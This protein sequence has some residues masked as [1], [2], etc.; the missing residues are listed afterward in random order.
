VRYA[1]GDG[2]VAAGLRDLHARLL[3]AADHAI[4]LGAPPAW[5]RGLDVWGRPPETLE[6]MRALKAQFDPKRV[7]NPGR[8]AGGI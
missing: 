7:L 4:M 2:G 6:V 1:L 3:D 8:F 5:K